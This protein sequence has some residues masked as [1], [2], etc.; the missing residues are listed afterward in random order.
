MAVFCLGTWQGAGDSVHC[1]GFPKLE[2]VVDIDSQRMENLPNGWS[3]FWFPFKTCPQRAPFWHPV[4]L[5]RTSS[6]SGSI[7][8]ISS[9]VVRVV[10][11]PVVL[12]CVLLVVVVVVVVLVKVVPACDNPLGHAANSRQ[13]DNLFPRAGGSTKNRFSHTHACLICELCINAASC[14][15]CGR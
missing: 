13:I 9:V 7:S 3:P 4:L 1:E 2:T 10:V 14:N 5:S 11:V 12:V 6:S 15:Q 8:R